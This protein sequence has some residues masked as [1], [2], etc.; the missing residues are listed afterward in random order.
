MY[1]WFNITYRTKI[2]RNAN[3]HSEKKA[4]N[5]HNRKTEKCISHKTEKKRKKN[6]LT[7]RTR[8]R[9]QWNR[10]STTAARH[11]WRRRRVIILFASNR[12]STLRHF[13]CASACRM[14][15]SSSIMVRLCPVLC[16]TYI[17]QSIGG[18]RRSGGAGGGNTNDNAQSIY[19]SVNR[20][21]VIL[22]LPCSSKT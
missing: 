7:V 10:E 3:T 6:R 21:N 8:K 19:T 13:R 2:V 22:R 4:K 14:R 17:S 9:N 20:L 11:P 18:G 15:C 12:T 5:T 16:R 1:I